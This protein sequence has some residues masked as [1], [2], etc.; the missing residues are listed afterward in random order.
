MTDV[1]L[2]KP[3]V[4]SPG[5]GPPAARTAHAPAPR[6]EMSNGASS[7]S[8]AVSVR[9]VTQVFD[10][11]VP[12]VL[13]GIDL[14][15]EPGEFVCLL[16]ASGCGKSTL[17]SIVAGLQEPTGGEVS[18]S[19]SRPALMFQEPAL[20]P[21]LT[22]GANI[23]LALRARGVPRKQ[24][25]TDAER[26]LGL[27]NLQGQH[28]KRVHELSGGMRQRVALARSLA[29]DSSVLLMDEP[30]A[31][32]DAITRDLLHEE[33]TRVWREQKLT[34]MFVT[35]NVREAVR[36]G[37]RVVLMGSRPGRIVR[38]W[39]I[40]LDQPRSI[41]SPGVSALAAEITTQ[42]R[43]EISRHGR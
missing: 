28:G 5:Y 13:D 37:Q 35:H 7:T 9:S 30:F 41:E 32:L 34:V 12:P 4:D 17:L 21:W 1:S 19:A 36:L 6:K 33:L 22:A 42:L 39:R 18:V 20:L 38:E 10:P 31:A 26:L 29:Q 2:A 8:A 24:R 25:R 23:E 15:V 14:E 3:S 11:T 16:G 40:E 27:V 43:Q